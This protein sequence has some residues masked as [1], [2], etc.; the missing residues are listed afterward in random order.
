MITNADR[1]NVYHL[2]T[3]NIEVGSW[4]MDRVCEDMPFLFRKTRSNDNS[5][6]MYVMRVAPGFKVVRGEGRWS[7]AYQE[8]NALTSK[9][10]KWE[11]DGELPVLVIE[12]RVG[13]L[14][15]TDDMREFLVIN[16]Q[17]AQAIANGWRFS[18]R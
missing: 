3:D 18:V 5:S 17:V 15:L 4:N 16:G 2:P 14:H 8:Q 12:L 1:S 13:E 9:M 11:T 6:R 10:V 7:A